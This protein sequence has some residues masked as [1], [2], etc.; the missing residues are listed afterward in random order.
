M[1]VAG[2]NWDKG[3]RAKCEKH[4]VSLEQI[5][6]FFQGEVSIAPDLKHSDAEERF[7]AIG[8]SDTGKPMIVAFTLR[9]AEEGN[10]IRPISARYMHAKEARRYDEAFAKD[11]DR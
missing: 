8:K 2:F 4:G 1:K 9:E 6:I 5:E 11:E 3:N 7:L 10:L